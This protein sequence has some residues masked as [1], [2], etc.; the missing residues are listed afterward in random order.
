[1]IWEYHVSFYPLSM[2]AVKLFGNN[3][4]EI[5]RQDFVL[6]NIVQCVNNCHS[7]EL[8]KFGIIY[9]FRNQDY[10]VSSPKT[11]HFVLVIDNFDV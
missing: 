5:Q 7:L 9:R 6:K 1:M 2:D 3:E 4:N 10:F 8:S 11:V